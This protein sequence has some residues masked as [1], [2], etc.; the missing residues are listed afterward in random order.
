MMASFFPDAKLTALHAYL[1][2]VAVDAFAYRQVYEMN[3]H[4]VYALSFW[5]TGNE[6]AAEELMGNVFR[7]VFARGIYSDAESIDRVLVAELREQMVIGNL[8]LNCE[9]VLKTVA[10][11][12]NAMRVHLERAVLDL[13]ATE[14]LVFLMHDVEGYD[15]ARIGRTI[16][17]TEEESRS[18]LHQAR[19]RVREL[20]AA[21]VC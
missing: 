6:I 10:V 15:H 12:R 9:T 11:R 1:P 5:M 19:L 18:A 14:R 13:P 7:R 21:M 2:A 17:V 20:L 4:R 16:G 8:S 3:R